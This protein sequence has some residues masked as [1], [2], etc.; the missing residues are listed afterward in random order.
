MRCTYLVG[1]D[2][3]MIVRQYSSTVKGSW[4]FV[5]LLFV[6]ARLNVT[7][8]NPEERI[9]NAAAMKKREAN[10]KQTQWSAIESKDIGK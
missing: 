7:I 1:K 9:A 10:S 2:S 3:K 8:E 6:E 4:W 5:S